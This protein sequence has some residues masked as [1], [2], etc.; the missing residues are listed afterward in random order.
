MTWQIEATREHLTQI[1]RDAETDAGTNIR[2]EQPYPID[3]DLPA[4]LVVYS[5]GAPGITIRQQAPRS[6]AIPA[7]YSIEGFVSDED[8]E[9]GSNADARPFFKR[10]DQLLR[11]VLATVLPQIGLDCAPGRDPC[12]GDE[13]TVLWDQTQLTGLEVGVADEGRVL[14]GAFRVTVRIAFEIV[15]DEASPGEMGLF[16]QANLQWDL[17]PIS[18]PDAEDAI[19]LPQS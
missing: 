7:T 14:Y 12:T 8:L 11:Q 9:S 6:Y 4:S 3:G 5:E 18:G 2:E 1:L 13:I 10:R 15:V 17:G 16:Q 19:A